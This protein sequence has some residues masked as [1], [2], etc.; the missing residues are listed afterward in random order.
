MLQATVA[1]MYPFSKLPSFYTSIG[2]LAGKASYYYSAFNQVY[3]KVYYI[4]AAEWK[5]LTHVH[6]IY[7]K[8]GKSGDKAKTSKL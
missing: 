6:F 4:L 7:A 8:K 3:P 2:K 5:N 1:G